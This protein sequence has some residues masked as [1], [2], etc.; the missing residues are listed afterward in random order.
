M[1]QYDISEGWYSPQAHLPYGSVI[2]TG[3]ETS[4]WLPD[5]CIFF[6]LSIAGSCSNQVVTQRLGNEHPQLQIK[7]IWFQGLHKKLEATFLTDW[8][9]FPNKCGFIYKC[10][11]ITIWF[12]AVCILV[13]FLYKSLVAEQLCDVAVKLP[14]CNNYVIICG[15][16]SALNLNLWGSGWTLNV[17]S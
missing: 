5:D 8:K 17:S 10:R 14:S 4:H 1:D 11:W 9:R 16:I 3:M 13:I 2:L 15:G 6:L 7:P 12:P